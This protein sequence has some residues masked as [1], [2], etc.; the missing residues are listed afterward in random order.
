MPIKDADERGCTPVVLL[1]RVETLR[2]AA[3]QR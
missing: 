3:D 2:I 1:Q